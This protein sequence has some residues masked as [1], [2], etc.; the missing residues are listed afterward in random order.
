MSR[1]LYCTHNLTVGP[2]AISKLNNV[3][4]RVLRKISGQCRFSA[5]DNMSDLKVRELCGKPSV[6]CLLVRS[7]LKYIRRV[8]RH[9]TQAL[10]LILCMRHKGKPIPW[11]LLL[12]SDFAVLRKHARAR[13]IPLPCSQAPLSKW[14][15]LFA[16]KSAWDEAVS[17]IYYTSSVSDTHANAGS[18][19][20]SCTYTCTQCPTNAEGLR[21]AWST[22]KALA[23]HARAKHKVLCKYRVYIGADGV[24]PV[25]MTAFKSRIRCLAHVSDARRTKCSSALVAG[26]YPQYD[27]ATVVQLD[28]SDREERRLAQRA[29]HSHPLAKGS[30]CTVHGR[31]VGRVSS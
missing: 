31:I 26:T 17:S 1:L 27:S 25:C 4:M 11:V 19:T 5:C 16:D 10:F 20:D 23:S 21:P 12:I 3:Y 7:R 30:A 15:E 28:L 18:S 29:G 13:S 6:D 8:C 9:P 2:K 22:A 14:T 24:C